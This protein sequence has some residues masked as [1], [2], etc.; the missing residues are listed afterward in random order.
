MKNHF[1]LPTPVIC[2]LVLVLSLVH[3]KSTLEPTFEPQVLSLV[4]SDAVEYSFR[5]RLHQ[6]ALAL[7]MRQFLV[8]VCIWWTRAKSWTQTS[9]ILYWI[10]SRRQLVLTK[11]SHVTRN[12]PEESMNRAMNLQS[13]LIRDP[14]VSATPRSSQL[15]SKVKQTNSRPSS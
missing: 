7:L 11:F 2:L 9:S 12:L 3:S 15:H 10:H 1:L 14:Q 6:F 5:L 13:L 8:H 4:I